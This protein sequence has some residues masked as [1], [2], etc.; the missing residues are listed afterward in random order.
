MKE[1]M[2]TFCTKLEHSGFLHEAVEVGDQVIPVVAIYEAFAAVVHKPA[3]HVSPQHTVCPVV[4][5]H[6]PAGRGHPKEGQAWQ[7]D[8]ETSCS[9]LLLFF[10][11]RERCLPPAGSGN[12]HK[13]QLISQF[14]DLMGL[15]WGVPGWAAARTELFYKESNKAHDS[16][17]V[18]VNLLPFTS[19][20]AC[21]FSGACPGVWWWIDTSGSD[22][23]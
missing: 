16:Y 22:A 18:T 3:Q 13:M 11:G 8:T 5:L 10:Q 19:M 14:C 12:N 7:R 4:L 21:G 23:N 9:I 1:Q 2:G 17:L 6:T 15:F 20:M